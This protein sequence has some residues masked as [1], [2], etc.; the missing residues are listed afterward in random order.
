MIRY[1][2]SRTLHQDFSTTLK[3]RVNAYFKH[4]NIR[5]NGNGEMVIKSVVALSLYFVPYAVMLLSGITNIP[6]L[7]T[8]WLLMG[9]GMT[10]IGTSVMHDAL[11]GSYSQKKSVNALMGFSAVVLGIDASLWKLQHNVLHHTYTNIEHADEDIQP[12]FVLRFTP[13]QPRKWFH[14]FQ[15]I[16]AGFFY[17]ISTLVWITVKDFIK[18]F[19]YRKKGLIKSG[20]AFRGHFMVIV[21]HK[22][23]YYFAFLILPILV[24]PVTARLTFLMFISMHMLTGL[25]ITLIF[26]T[27]HV[28]PTSDF[29]E[30]EQQAIDQNWLVHQIYTTSNYAMKN[31]VLSWF[32]GG[33]NFQ[34]EH[35][36]FPNI[37]HIHYPKIA[38]IVQ[39][40]TR[41]FNLPYHAQKSFRLAIA[42]HFRMLRELGN[43]DTIYPL[44]K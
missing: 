8:L 20:K 2:F 6:L 25:L 24:L 42:N 10:F 19:N 32:I 16:Y 37:C 4:H 27:A 17:S 41:E 15:H 44:G 21:F 1:K 9:L 18:L 13:N 11:H 7:F 40:T 30:Q 3:K 29:V 38:Q 31:K 35:H 14:R 28:M 5:R 23:L 39:Q 33:L 26:Q 36:L 12:R 34:I 43:R 22:L